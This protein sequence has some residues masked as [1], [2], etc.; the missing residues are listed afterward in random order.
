[1][2]E[3]HPV[4][5]FDGV[6]NLCNGA[7]RFVIKRDNKRYFRFASIQSAY[8]QQLLNT[9]QPGAVDQLNTFYLLEN[10]RLYDRSTAA[11]RITRHLSGLWPVLYALLIIPKFIRDNVYKFIAANRYKWFGKQDIC[12][13][14]APELK[15]L[16]LG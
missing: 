5:L 1:V 6:C 10:G 9:Y 2:N 3:Q 7:I 13:L 14:P 15:E 11:L 8:G 16:F 12:Q 4:I